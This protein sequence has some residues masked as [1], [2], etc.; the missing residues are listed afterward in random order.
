MTRARLLP[1]LLFAC[2]CCPSFAQVRITVALNNEGQELR[3]N[4]T[5]ANCRD[6]RIDIR[7]AERSIEFVCFRPQD[8][9]VAPSL[10]MIPQVESTRQIEA[11][12]N[13]RVHINNRTFSGCN[14]IVAIPAELLPEAARTIEFRYTFLCKPDRI[15]HSSFDD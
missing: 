11:L 15:A 8:V 10:A 7:P 6:D 13:W 14:W 3:L 2:V 1:I 9:I 4:P 12:K 5:D